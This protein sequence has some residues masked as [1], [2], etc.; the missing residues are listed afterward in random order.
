MFFNANYNSCEIFL[1]KTQASWTQHD[2]GHSCLFEKPVYNRYLQGL[3]LG[4]IKGA[5]PEWWALTHNMHHAKPNVICK[6]PDVKADPLLIFGDEQ[7]RQ[8]NSFFFLK[9]LWNLYETIKDLV[10]VL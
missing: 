7:M 9:S 5:S 8:V 10:S 2:Y 4:V 3:F 6:D 1:Q